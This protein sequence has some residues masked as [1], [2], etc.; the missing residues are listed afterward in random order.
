MVLSSGAALA[1]Q[2][3]PIDTVPP[4]VDGVY[5]EAV[6][7]L[8]ADLPRAALLE[9]GAL[10]VRG[11]DFRD[12]LRAIAA[13]TGMNLLVDD[14]IEQRVTVA[15]QDVRAI[16]AVAALVREYGLRLEQSGSVFRVRRAA[17]APPPAPPPGPV[18]D[19][20]FSGAAGGAGRLTIDAQGA[21]A[22]LVARRITEASGTNVIV[23]PGAGQVPVRAYLAGVPV[24]TALRTLAEASGLVLR[25]SGGV[26]RLDALPQPPQTERGGPG[27]NAPRRPGGRVGVRVE[28]G[29]AWLDLRQAPL[30]AVLEELAAGA[31]WGLASY[32]PTDGIAVT[33]DAAAL[34]IRRAFEVVLRG[35]G[36]A[37]REQNGLVLVG[38]AENGGVTESRLVRMGYVRADRAAEL[39]PPSVTAQA[40]VQAVPD[41]NA[42]LVSGPSGAVA[43]VVDFLSEIDRPAPQVLIEA[44][45]VEFL[46][47]SFR[48]LGFDF[49]LGVFETDSL[50]NAVERGRRR[51]EFGGADGRFT[52]E[53]DGADVNYALDEADGRFGGLFGARS[54]G[55]LPDDFYFRIRALEQQGRAE[56][57]TRPQLATVSGNTAT[58]SVGRTQYYLLET[59]TPIQSP[60]DVFTQTTQRFEK[61]EANTNLSVTPFV[62]PTGEITAEI[63]PEF[64]NPVG[65]FTAGVPPEISTR[66]I[67]STVRLRD[68]ETIVLGGLVADEESVD[69]RRIPILGRIPLLGRLFSSKVTTVRRSELV[70]YLTPY[71]FYG[72]PQEGRRWSEVIEEQGYRPTDRTYRDVEQLRWTGPRQVPANLPDYG[73]PSGPAAP[74]III[75]GLGNERP[76]PEDQDADA[77]ST[78]VPPPPPGQAP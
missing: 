42:V 62:S 48:E 49:G 71:V 28:A 41:Q 45:V 22:E 40:A 73:P 64:S 56:V 74:R 72:S 5:G 39:L 13:E 46:D 66:V 2:P 16:D 31:G 60:R 44:L 11:A 10:S 57:R 27:G 59:T 35:T 32:A 68:G 1:Q 43:E 54:I 17:A 38:D 34:P 3:L 23:G 37:F 25:E 61:I 14:Q 36:L 52:F 30:G 9:I 65:Q 67:E 6:I 50:G 75:E 33:V 63:R 18:A 55:R 47:D 21:P 19:V 51:Y 69:E 29:Y 4:A 20:S 24:E 8:E 77:D 76:D 70:I 53:G 7:E 15:F 58:L 12:V 78:D 26:Y